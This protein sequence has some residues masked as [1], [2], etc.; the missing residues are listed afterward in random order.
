M[1]SLK[2][3]KAEEVKKRVDL[4]LVNEEKKYVS[5]TYKKIISDNIFTFFNLIFL[6]IAILLIIARDFKSLTFIP[7][8]LI[9][10]S[11]G[12]VQEIKSK[13]LI[14]KLTL[15]NECEI[16]TYRDSSVVK[17]KSSEL[18]RDDVVIFKSGN[19]IV[20]DARVIDGKAY[21]NESLLTGESLSV[22]KQ[23]GD[24]LYSGSFVTQGEVT[25]ILTNVG[26][27]SY[28][29]KLTKKAKES[30]DNHESEIK[31][32][33]NKLL[34][35][36]SVI[37]VPLA[38]ALIIGG[39]NRGEG[40]SKSISSMAGSILM[41]IPEGLFLLSSVSLAISAYRLAKENVLIQSM[42][43][44]E[45]LARI[46]VLCLDKTGTITTSKL[47]VNS[48][49]P[50]N[51]SEDEFV[52]E[53]SSF[54]YY[55][56]PDNKTMEAIKA[57]FKN[58]S[59]Y[60][61]QSLTSFS[62]ELKYSST[63]FKNH[64]IIVGALEFV[65]KEDYSK[66]KSEADKYASEGYRVLALARTNSQI[67]DNKTL[68]NLEFLGFILLEDSIRENAISTF[69][70]FE[71]QGV[72]IKVISG[73]SALTVSSVAKRAGIKN[74]DKYIDASELNLDDLDNEVL[75]YTVFGRVTPEIKQR[76]VIALK[77]NNKKV[78]MT[79]DGVND[80][81]ALK[82]ANLSVAMREGADAAVKVA[83][84]VLLDSDF[85]HMPSI[86][87]EGR[88]VVNN[89]ERSGSLFI[90]KNIFSIL[91]T[92]FCII[93]NLTF[94]IK[95]T[96]TSLINTFA[97]GLPAFLISLQSSNKLIKGSFISNIL[98]CAIPSGLVEALM[99]II[100]MEVGLNNG[101]SDLEVSSLSTILMG[102]IGTV[103]IFNIARP[104]TKYK[105]T[106]CIICLI[107]LALNVLLALKVPFFTNYYAFTS[108]S[109]KGWKF[110]I[111]FVPISI[112]S[113]I[114]LYALFE[115]LNVKRYLDILWK[116]LKKAKEKIVK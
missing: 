40:F 31:S 29:S 97:I 27:D 44:I 77:N 9:N 14:D 91:L 45:T 22:E 35:I 64:S 23:V 105:I 13:K 74:A 36:I 20:A 65:F 92:I 56:K 104:Y 37:I 34:V 53:V 80:V 66:Y 75:K 69:K 18:V 19:Q 98:K 79:G 3:L 48:F 28:I 100:F 111:I 116:K 102:I 15:L 85:S 106:V 24:T 7:L 72:D 4:G 76:L 16:D 50:Y 96:Q 59:S 90:T 86:V 42:D 43:S 30:K 39:L 89:L 99:I 83:Q 94:P 61:F 10:L 110:A 113:Y 114:L 25:C 95:P 115:K 52:K 88:K 112:A 101:I 47:N 82:E 32:S 78:A 67:T 49:K 81:L 17:V 33:L 26:E 21:L 93:L 57:Y 54:A 58:E 71:E 62:S 87:F 70:Y 12:I 2:G 108:I 73:D 51:I 109:I 5:K 1:S 38:L 8:L 6:I 41:M 84:V 55:Q 68:E 60:E 63:S 103:V 107:G 11:I 46:N